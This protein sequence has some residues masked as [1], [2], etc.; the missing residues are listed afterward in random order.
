[1]VPV[2]KVSQPISKF[3]GKIWID[4]RGC[5]SYECAICGYKFM[6]SGAFEFHIPVAHQHLLAQASVTSE[7]GGFSEVSKHHT[8]CGHESHFRRREYQSHRPH[9]H[10]QRN[11]GHPSTEKR[12]P[13]VHQTMFA[14]PSAARE[15]REVIDVSNRHEPPMNRRQHP[16]ERQHSHEH[17]RGDHSPAPKRIGLICTK[18]TK[19]FND[20]QSLRTHVQAHHQFVCQ[21]CPEQT[22]K[23]FDTEKGLWSHQRSR[24]ATMFPYR[25]RVCPRAFTNEALLKLHMQDKHSRGPMQSI[26]CDFCPRIMMSAFEKSNHIKEKHNDRRYHCQ[27]CTDYKTTNEIN[28]RRHTK[29][30]HPGQR[31][32]K[33]R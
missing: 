26:K 32:P 19:Q 30:K 28:L 25:C 18:C 27:L 21:F 3:G 29:E 20:L 24:H 9:F 23:T 2:T 13:T 6:S 10:E 31:Q 11:S 16:S 17:R 15:S 22:V 33:Q 14:Q 7:S 12:I 8:S 5:C 1:M 4:D